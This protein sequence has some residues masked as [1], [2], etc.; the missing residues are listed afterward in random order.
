MNPYDTYDIGGTCNKSEPLSHIPEYPPPGPRDFV[1]ILSAPLPSS[2]SF[3]DR[4]LVCAA[5]CR[6]SIS[7]ASSGRRSMIR[8]P[9]FH[10][11]F[12]LYKREALSSLYQMSSPA[13]VD[14][15][16]AMLAISFLSTHAP[17]HPPT[18]LPTCIDNSIDASSRS[19]PTLPANSPVSLLFQLCCA[20][21]QPGDVTT[22]LAADSVFKYI[23]F[24]LMHVQ[25]LIDTPVSASHCPQC[26]PLNVQLAELEFDSIGN[27]KGTA[28][29]LRTSSHPA[30]SNR[31]VEIAARRLLSTKQ[32]GL[33]SRGRLLMATM[34][35]F[36]SILWAPSW[37][38]PKYKA[39][40]N[41][42]K[43]SQP[44]CT[45][46]APGFSMHTD[47]GGAYQRCLDG[48]SPPRPTIRGGHDHCNAQRRRQ[49]DPQST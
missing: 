12:R 37:R 16:A 35:T 42:K 34:H 4:R 18:Q 2:E 8:K 43:P 40:C 48:S 22:I 36:M 49:A 11:A 47:A 19:T 21:P 45:F 28:P 17:T 10:D 38:S 24:T 30:R 41:K 5:I 25:Q 31:V 39:K 13:C 32:E 27:N 1:E 3:R 15:L 33:R 14:T 7:N 20:R 6:F 29:P 9:P 46:T 44:R 23:I 26:S